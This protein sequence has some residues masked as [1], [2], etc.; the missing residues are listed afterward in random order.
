MRTWAAMFF[1]LIIKQLSAFAGVLENG[2]FTNG[3]T[4]WTV[5]HCG[6]GPAPGS[7]TASSGQALLLEGDSAFVS[8]SQSF[9][10]PQQA[11]TL[12]FNFLTI[13]G[14]NQSDTV[15]PDAFE[16][17]LLKADKTSAVPRWKPEAT[18]FFNVQENA[19]T[20]LA[21]GV[22]FA[23]DLVTLN[24]SGVPAGTQVTL[25]FDLLGADHD[26]FGG[27]SID[28]VMIAGSVSC[29]PP[30]CDDNNACTVDGCQDGQCQHVPLQC[31]TGQECL[32][33][34]CVTTNDPCADLDGDGKI[35]ICHI[36]PGNPGNAKTIKISVNALPAHLAHGD[37]CGPCK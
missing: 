33:G 36:P 9:A 35:L 28:N 14:F 22:T 1:F 12:S 8:L 30:N 26:K 19:T 24:I 7:I 3:L 25:F 11:Q 18:S 37:Y 17:S 4:G 29:D 27:V 32:N 6:D 23:G 13:P 16:V 34:Q 2:G 10:I 20:H 31:P 15:F 21:Q 5:A